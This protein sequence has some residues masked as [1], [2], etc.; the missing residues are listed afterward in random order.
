MAELT[1]HD[2]SKKMADI[3]FVMLQTHTE[4]GQIAARPMSNNQDVEYDG[5]SWF[6]I[7][8]DT[9]TFFDVQSNPKVGLSIQGSKSLLGAPGIF[10][11]VEG[12]AEIIRDKAAFKQHW[13]KDLER[14]WKDGIDTPGLALLKVHAARIHYWHGEDEGEIKV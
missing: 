10:I 11:S 7:T 2:I 1:L 3:D 5:D 4:N 12:T 9:R 6:F 14:W 8:D 13:V